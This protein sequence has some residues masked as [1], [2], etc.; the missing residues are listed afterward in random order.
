MITE[1]LVNPGGTY[2]YQG[3]TRVFPDAKSVGWSVG[4]EAP[5]HHQQDL[6]K[7]Q[8]AFQWPETVIVDEATLTAAARHPAIIIIPVA[9]SQ[10]RKDFGAGKSDDALVPPSRLAARAVATRLEYDI[11]A[12]LASRLGKAETFDGGRSADD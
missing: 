8:E 12:D 6:N 1:T 4:R 5:F 10:E 11:Y 3:K 7:L 9:M 2:R